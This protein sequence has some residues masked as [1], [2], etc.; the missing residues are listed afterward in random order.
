MLGHSDQIA[1]ALGLRIA[2][3]V[4]HLVVAGRVP[5]KSVEFRSGLHS[6]VRPG[7]TGRPHFADDVERGE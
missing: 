4:Y 6:P 2:A 3:V 7:F 5:T 1:T